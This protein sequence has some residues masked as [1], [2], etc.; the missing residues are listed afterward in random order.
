MALRQDLAFDSLRNECI[1]GDESQRNLVSNL[2][3]LVD[4]RLGFLVFPQKLDPG[5]LSRELSHHTRLT[6][7]K[8][9]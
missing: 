2:W 1:N 4:Q 5:F 7:S 9:V 6:L 3:P 8:N